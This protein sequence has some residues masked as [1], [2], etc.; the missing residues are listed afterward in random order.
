MSRGVLHAKVTQ[1][2]RLSLLCVALAN[3]IVGFLIPFTLLLLLFFLP[4]RLLVGLRVRRL[5][6]VYVRHLGRGNWQTRGMVGLYLLHGKFMQL[7]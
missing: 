6:T 3:I 2:L 1:I 4:F 7:I 5:H